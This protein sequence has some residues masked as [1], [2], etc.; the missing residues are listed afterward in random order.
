MAKAAHDNT[1]FRRVMRYQIDPLP[2]VWVVTL[3]T[4]TVLIHL[5]IWCAS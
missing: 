1:R 5:A 2:I 3:C 4:W